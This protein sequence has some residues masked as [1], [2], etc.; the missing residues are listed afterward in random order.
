MQ[1]TY[2]EHAATF[3]EKIQSFLAEHLPPDWKG[4]GALDADGA[5]A[6]T[7]QWRDILRDNKLLAASWPAEYGGAGLSALESVIMAE[8]FQKAGVPTGGRCSARNDW[9]FSRKVA[10]CSL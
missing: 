1:P 6:F 8:E 2:S 3:R 4:I 7:D 9:I 10:A 5:H